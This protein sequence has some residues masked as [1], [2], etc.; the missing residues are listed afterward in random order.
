MN[1]TVFLV[2]V[3]ALAACSGGSTSAPTPVDPALSI[4]LFSDIRNRASFASANLTNTG[5]ASYDGYIDIVDFSDSSAAIGELTATV[6]F[7]AG[8][9]SMSADNWVEVDATTDEVVTGSLSG[10]GTLT[11]TSGIAGITGDLSGKVDDVDIDVVINGTFTGS[12]GSVP[13]GL[14]GGDDS[15]THSVAFALDD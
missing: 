8:T 4:A 7:G 12:S 9:Y 5:S 3:V 10:T 13:D 1:R 14:I 6:N 2:P 11:N 15:G